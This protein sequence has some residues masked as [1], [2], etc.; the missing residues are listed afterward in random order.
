MKINISIKKI[1]E[2]KETYYSKHKEERKEYYKL[3]KEKIKNYKKEYYIKNKNKLSKE[4][5]YYYELYQEEFKKY[6]HDYYLKNKEKISKQGKQYRNTHK[7]EMIEYQLKYRKEHKK[8][9]N[10]HHRNRLKS[11][12]NYKI[13]CNLRI[14]LWQGVTEFC[15]SVSTMKLLGC[16]IDFLKKHLESQFKS[17]MSWSNYGKWHVDHIRPCASFDLSKPEEQRKCFHYTNLQPLWAKDNLKKGQ[18]C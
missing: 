1:F 18:K 17:G 11:D 3:N 4:Q 14:R 9:R 7:K 5:K 10:E 13:I 15:K 16:S 6:K 12:I 8:E 2:I